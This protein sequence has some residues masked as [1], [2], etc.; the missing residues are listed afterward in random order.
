M[1]LFGFFFTSLVF[2]SIEK[3]VSAMWTGTLLFTT[4][5][6]VPEQCEACNRC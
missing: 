4:V 3:I 1:I 6:Q 5:A 2:E